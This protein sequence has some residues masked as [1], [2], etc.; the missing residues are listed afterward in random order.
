MINEKPIPA[1]QTR[2]MV[3]FELLCTLP[4]KVVRTAPFEGK[5][6]CICDNGSIYL[7]DADGNCEVINFMEPEE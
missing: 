2:P 4:S 6:L 7:V 3:G 5:L 1:L